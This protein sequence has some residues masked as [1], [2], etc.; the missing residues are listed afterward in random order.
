MIS[1]NSKTSIVIHAPLAKVWEGLTKAEM[2]KQYLFGT[3]MVTTWE[4]GSP[5]LF[6]GEWEGKAYEDK[7]TVLEYKP[8]ETFSYSYWSG[9]S[10]SEDKPENYQNIRFDLE[11]VDSDNVKVTITQSNV[12]T[13]ESADH[14]SDNW[15]K[16]LEN[17]KKL[18]EK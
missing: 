5:V 8:Q 4:V 6:R 2:V 1:F 7:G 17:M 16:V 12:K 9:F 11:T 14:S 10:G 18:L 3:N 13:Q 15:Q